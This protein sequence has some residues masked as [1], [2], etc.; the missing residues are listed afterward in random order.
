MSPQ[1]TGRTRLVRSAAV[2][3]ALAVAAVVLPAGGAAALTSASVGAL[4]AT[5]QRVHDKLVRRSRLAA[6][7]PDFAGFVTDAAGQ[8]L[9]AHHRRERQ[10]PASNA[11][12]VTAVNALHVFGQDYRRTTRVVQGI[13]ARRVVLVGAA[14]PSLRGRHLMHL[15]RDA[16]AYARAH[17]LK[18][19][20]VLVDDS[21]FP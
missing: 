6:L 18:S 20:R 16:A 12:L 9:W 11:K 14:D 19:V 17:D 15:A 21:L 5:D 3:A 2:S 10:L 13:R 8:V 7:G 1:L 4:S